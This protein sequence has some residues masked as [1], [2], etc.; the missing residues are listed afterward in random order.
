MIRA[1]IVGATG[2]TGCELLD[3]LIRHPEVEVT[4]L[5]AKIDEAAPRVL[6]KWGIG[7]EVKELVVGARGDVDFVA[8]PVFRRAQV[9]QPALEPHGRGRDPAGRRTGGAAGPWRSYRR[10]HHVYQEPEAVLLVQLPGS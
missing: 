2:Y 9:L 8:G 3:I 4:S 5:T 7:G 1:A 6:A 10:L